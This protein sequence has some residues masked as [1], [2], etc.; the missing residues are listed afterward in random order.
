MSLVSTV[1]L[2]AHATTRRFLPLYA[3]IKAAI[4]P[5]VAETIFD[6]ANRMDGIVIAERI[7]YGKYSKK[8][9]TR[10]FSILRLKRTKGSI[11]SRYVTSTITIKRG[12]KSLLSMRF[13]LR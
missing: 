9:L 1:K 6:V 5:S 7:A 8:R 11:L 4:N 3:N 2:A 13:L 10:A 12:K